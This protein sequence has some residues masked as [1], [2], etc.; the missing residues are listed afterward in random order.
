MRKGLAEILFVTVI[1]A[2]LEQAAPESGFLA[3]LNDPRI[4]AALKLMHDLPDKEWTL[5]SLA[6]NVAMSRS[7]FAG[8]F[9]K[10]VGETRN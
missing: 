8:R 10:L 6:K 2:Y 9:K 3:A 4:S 1:R 7:V 5:N